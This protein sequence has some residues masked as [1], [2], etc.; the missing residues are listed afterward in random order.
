MV[1]DFVKGYFYSQEQEYGFGVDFRGADF[2]SLVV[3]L[4]FV[5]LNIQETIIF[6][7]MKTHFPSDLYLPIYFQ[8]G[9][10][11]LYFDYYPQFDVLVHFTSLYVP[12]INQLIVVTLPQLPLL[13]QYLINILSLHRPLIALIII[14]DL[15]QLTFIVLLVLLTFNS[16]LVVLLAAIMIVA[17]YCASY[18]D[19]VFL[20]APYIIYVYFNFGL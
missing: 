6:S 5:L 11:P 3:L 10:I 17:A 9:A 2:Y 7:F 8:L 14:Y 19:L 13:H 18:L 1:A 12:L 20:M 16:Y 15:I 4:I